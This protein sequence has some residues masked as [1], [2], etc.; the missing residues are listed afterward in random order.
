MP[1]NGY[2]AHLELFWFLR[3]SG[4]KNVNKMTK[5]GIFDP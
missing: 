3:I 5:N 2:F 4:G 1:K